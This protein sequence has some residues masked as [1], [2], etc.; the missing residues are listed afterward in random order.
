MSANS[1]EPETYRLTFAV[2]IVATWLAY[3]AVRKDYF[4][5][6]LTPGLERYLLWTISASAVLSFLSLLATASTLKTNNKN[7]AGYFEFSDKSRAT[8]YDLSV[9]IL[10]IA[11]LIFVSTWF[12]A[13]LHNHFYHEPLILG[14]GI[15]IYLFLFI[16][17]FQAAWT[18]TIFLLNQLYYENR[19]VAPKLVKEAGML[20]WCWFM[21]YEFLSYYFLTHSH[22]WRVIFLALFNCAFWLGV[23]VFTPLRKPYLKFGELVLW[24]PL[25]KIVKVVRRIK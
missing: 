20:L 19:K 10:G 11:P 7:H 4:Q 6:W 17:L 14:L 21:S 22:F 15:F 16:F 9:D 24:R 23:L 1:G 13:W 8:L 2:G 18:F 12:L 5:K 3:L 25:V